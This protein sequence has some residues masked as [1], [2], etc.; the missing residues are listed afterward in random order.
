M[1]GRGGA[2]ATASAAAAAAAAAPAAYRV[3]DKVVCRWRDDTVRELGAPRAL[4]WW[5]VRAVERRTHRQ[6]KHPAARALR[7]RAP[8]RAD[9]A[10]IIDERVRSSKPG[11]GGAPAANSAKGQSLLEEREYYVHYIECA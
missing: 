9:P 8:R 10:E 5:G 11:D 7:A 2:G 4:W 3:K 6:R 1:S